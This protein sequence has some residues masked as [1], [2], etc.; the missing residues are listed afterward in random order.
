MDVIFFKSPSEFREWL[1]RNHERVLEQWVGFYKKNSGEPS[2]TWPESVDEALCF[3]WIDGLR[4][5]IDDVSYKIRFTPRRPNSVWSQV[6][7]KRI[8]Q[9]KMAGLVTAAGLKAL[10]ERGSERPAKEASAS[11][12][13][14]QLEARFRSSKK[15]WAFFEMQPPG[16]RKLVVGYV[17]GAKREATQSRRLDIVIGYCEAEERIDFMKP[18]VEK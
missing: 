13:S 12:L 5:S 14:D 18:L 8:E 17:M 6:N 16:Y 2:I 11:S 3:G 4:K 10:K 9:L 15:A 7:L 1:E